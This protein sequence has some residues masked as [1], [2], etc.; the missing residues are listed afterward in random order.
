MTKQSEL[1]GAADLGS[2]PVGWERHAAA[3]GAHYELMIDGKA[4]NNWVKHCG[5]PTALR[6]YYVRLADGRVL[7]R[8]HRLLDDAKAAA[9]AAIQGTGD[10]P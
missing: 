5:H 6:P 10:E 3:V 1:F 9:I 7:E 8:K 2:P 4:T